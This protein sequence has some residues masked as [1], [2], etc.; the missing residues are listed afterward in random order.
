ML[1]HRTTFGPASRIMSL[2]TECAGEQ[3]AFWSFHDARIANGSSNVAGQ[4]SLARDLGLNVSQFTACMEEERYQ[5][6]LEEDRAAGQANGIFTQPAFI[7][8]SGG[9][10]TKLIGWKSAEQLSAVIDE[11][12]N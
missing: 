4:V 5:T 6:S 1:R 9:E 10:S 11:Y 3:D 12:L 8:S 7:I 2:G